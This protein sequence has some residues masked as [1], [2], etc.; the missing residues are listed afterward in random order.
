MEPR[1]VGRGVSFTCN[2]LAQVSE[3]LEDAKQSFVRGI[4][5]EDWNFGSLQGFTQ[6]SF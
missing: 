5:N 4:V 6:S 2:L 3:S 1:H